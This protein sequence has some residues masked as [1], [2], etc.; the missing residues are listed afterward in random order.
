MPIGTEVTA[1]WASQSPLTDP[2]P[3]AGRLD[4]LPDDLD[5]IRDAARQLVFHY[6]AGGDWAEHGI[7]PERIAEI[8]TRSGDR[9]LGRRVEITGAPLGTPRAACDRLVGCCRDFTVLFLAM[10]RHKGIPARARVGFATYF[11]PGWNLDHVV[12]EVWDEDEGRWR[13]I[14]AELD[15]GHIDRADGATLDPLDLPRDRFITGPDA[16]RACRAGEADPERFVVAPDLDIPD[17][18][19][20]PYLMHN[21]AHDLASLNQHEML[22]WEDWGILLHREALLPDHLNLLD[23][24]ASITALPESTPQQLAELF[25]R[26]EFRV[27]ESVLSFSPARQDIPF[28]VELTR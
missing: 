10:A 14:D 6:R 5:A 11:V 12:A 19:G 23:Q 7:A 15:A 16:W 26:D 20:W 25:A 1:T 18:R 27:P 13:L 8:G 4:A 3:L 17:T 24:V 2:G 9:M 22:L 21:L 28:T